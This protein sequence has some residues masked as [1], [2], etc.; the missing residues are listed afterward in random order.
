MILAEESRCARNNTTAAIILIDLDGLKAV[1]D[2]LGH[3]AGDQLI[4]LAADILT[5]TVR[6]T[7]T[8]ARLGGDEFAVLASGCDV[9][10]A[11]LLCQRLRAELGSAGV[12]ASIGFGHRAANRT[13]HSAW[14]EA[15]EAM[16]AD[17]RNRRRFI[18]VR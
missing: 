6:P 2:R 4:C 17:K 9:E 16:Y 3:S 7:D 10:G 5:R 18:V 1:N 15:D 8:V 12:D 13:M 14:G 11:K